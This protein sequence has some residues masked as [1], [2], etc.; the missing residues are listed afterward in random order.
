MGDLL[1]TFAPKHHMMYHWACKARYLNPRRSACLI[2]EDYVGIIKNIVRRCTA[3]TQ[4]H[5]VAT[6]VMEKYRWGMHM[7]HRYGK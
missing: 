5:D 7:L 3:G 2:D 1:F 6:K 4:L